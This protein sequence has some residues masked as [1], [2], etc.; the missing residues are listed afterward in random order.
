MPVL[1]V[2][3][4]RRAAT[5][6]V[7]IGVGGSSRGASDCR[8]ATRAAPTLPP[9]GPWPCDGGSKLASPVPRHGECR[10]GLVVVTVQPA[11][12]TKHTRVRSGAAPDVRRP[13]YRSSSVSAVPC[14]RRA[15]ERHIMSR[16]PSPVGHVSFSDSRSPR[17]RAPARCFLAASFGT[18]ACRRRE[19]T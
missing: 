15:S 18:A 8:S 11:H 9:P 13:R 10:H 14:V 12:R 1:T 19:R 16:I 4:R 3:S 7:G 5:A 17:G 2:L 6:V